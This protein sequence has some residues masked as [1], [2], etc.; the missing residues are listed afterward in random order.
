[1]EIFTGNSSPSLNGN[2][3]TIE[4]MVAKQ[5][6]ALKS[7]RKTGELG[8]D[9]F[10]HLLVT[11]LKYQD[12]LKPME[13]KEFISQMAQFSSL[14]QMINLNNSFS[15]IKAVSMIGREITAVITDEIS[16]T[17]KN[18]TGFVESVKM[19]NGS[20]YLIVNGQQVPADKVTEILSGSSEK[21]TVQEK[22]VTDQ[23]TEESEV[24]PL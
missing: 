10:I 18:I 1:M 14:E 7:S 6:T 15:A 9:D 20:V 5:A 22:G 17:Q 23:V 4:Q 19:V 21:N 13:D 3:M 12:P 24:Q 16:S 2:A 11:Q 8:K